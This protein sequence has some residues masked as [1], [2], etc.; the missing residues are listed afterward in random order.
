[1]PRKR[2]KGTEWKKLGW[3]SLEFHVPGRL[4]LR[5]NEKL[6][7]GYT[8]GDSETLKDALLHMQDYCKHHPNGNEKI[9]GFVKVVESTRLGNTDLLDLIPKWINDGTI[10]ID[11]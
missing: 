9:R 11:Q 2:A 8:I 1:M 3:E 5:H 6:Q 7:Y 4:V 10:V